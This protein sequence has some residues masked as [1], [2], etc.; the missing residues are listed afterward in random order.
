MKQK[1]DSVEQIAA[2]LTEAE[3]GAAVDDRFS[4]VLACAINE[5]E[6]PSQEVDGGEC[7]EALG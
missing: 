1:W 7:P 2:V 3:R 6:S 4:N 5:E